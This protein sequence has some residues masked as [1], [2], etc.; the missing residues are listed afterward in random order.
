MLSRVI[1]LVVMVLTKQRPATA[2]RCRMFWGVI[3][4]IQHKPSH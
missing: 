1:I 4:K 2:G 3:S